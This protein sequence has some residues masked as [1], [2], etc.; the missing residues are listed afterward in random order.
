MRTT[1]TVDEA[2]VRELVEVTGAGTKTAAVRLAVVE[3]IRLAR[4]RR[5]A[6]LL[7]TVEVDDDALA[8]GDRLDAARAAR[9]D[10]GRS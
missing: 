2:L 4:L 5:L 10:E 1:V 6:D 8:H 7:G 3:Q 9:L